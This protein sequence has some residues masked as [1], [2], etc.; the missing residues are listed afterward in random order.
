MTRDPPA[1]YYEGFAGTGIYNADTLFP[2]ES[3]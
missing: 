1:G 2:L 3:Y